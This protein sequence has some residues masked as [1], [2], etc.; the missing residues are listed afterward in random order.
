M[1][2]YLLH[3]NIV[4]LVTALLAA[5]RVELCSSFLSTTGSRR[6]QRRQ[7]STSAH[8]RPL[9]TIK[10]HAS[11]KEKAADSAAA[12][13]SSTITDLTSLRKLLSQ[14][15]AIH[16]K[17]LA[18]TPP[19]TQI[20]SRLHDLEIESS[21]PSFWDASNNARNQVVTKEIARYTKLKEEMETWDKLRTD[22][23]DALELLEELSS[24]S[25][26]SADQQQQ[27]SDEE[28]MILLTQEECQSSAQQLLQLSQKYELSTLLSG[29]Y[30]D[31]PCRIL[32]TAGAGGT[33]ACDWV[34][35]LYRMY[36]RH[37]SYMDMTCKVIDESPGDVVGYK[38][39]ELQ[40]DGSN[41][42]GWF[43]GE[44]GAHRLVRLSPFN[45]NNKRQ[46]TFAGVDVVPI[47]DDEEITTVDIPDKELE[48]TTMRSGG[49]GGQNVNKVETGVRIKHIP[50]GIAVKCTEERSQSMNKQLAMNRIK[51]QL[52]AIVQEQRLQD[53]NA[54]RGD[55]VEASW[56]AQ[57][58]NYV[59]Q[60]YKMVKDQRSEW[61]TSDVDGVLDGGS[62]LEE[63]VGAWLR[64]MRAKE[65]KE[66]EEMEAGL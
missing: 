4:I 54:I 51:A 25:S 6:H 23:S 22:A 49:K 8:A 18:S 24:D 34:S 42:Y 38:S 13:V 65:E 21:D 16:D 48:I 27:Q 57:I 52:L 39:I 36:S 12:A 50:S 2:Y 46:T 63:F 44:K 5:H 29:P 9:R 58:R 56:G 32:L 66:R 55:V 43:K 10:L 31:S 35:M 30:D 1:R 26:S 37:A 11:S 47:L 3:I 53:I 33:E 40:I 64:W 62:A 61:E 19:Y 45:A 41:A 17:N 60:P 7:T 14:A 59:M 15:T 28:E 20:K